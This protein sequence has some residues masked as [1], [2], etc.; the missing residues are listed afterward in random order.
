MK[1]TSLMEE[2]ESGS[3][4]YCCVPFAFWASVSVSSHVIPIHWPGFGEG[5]MYRDTF[6]ICDDAIETVAC[7]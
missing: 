3:P 7:V 4:W 1:V 2:G 6:G 5:L